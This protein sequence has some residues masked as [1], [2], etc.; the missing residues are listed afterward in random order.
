MSFWNYSRSGSPL[1]FRERSFRVFLFSCS[2]VRVLPASRLQERNL[3]EN[4]VIGKSNVVS[5]YDSG[6]SCHPIHYDVTHPYQSLCPWRNSS[7]IL[8]LL[9][10]ERSS[11]YLLTQKNLDSL[12]CARLQLDRNAS[13]AC[14][15]NA[16]RYVTSF[17]R[18]HFRAGKLLIRNSIVC[19]SGMNVTK[20]L[21]AK[22]H[23]YLLR[24][25]FSKSYSKVK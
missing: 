1:R 21:G 4:V 24:Y 14:N 23:H 6:L 22:A 9:R 12:D 13:R 2:N 5:C 10:S 20:I 19:G 18:S 17:C 3:Y 16:L 8:S 7:Q 15:H 25:L 11:S